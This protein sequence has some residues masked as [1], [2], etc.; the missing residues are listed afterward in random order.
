M[1]VSGALFFAL[2]IRVQTF[3]LINCETFGS[4]QITDFV[5]ELEKSSRSVA[6]FRI[7]GSENVKIE[8]KILRF[9]I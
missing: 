3:S 5:F 2:K 4:Y 6:Y 9:K 8:L 1:L 7:L